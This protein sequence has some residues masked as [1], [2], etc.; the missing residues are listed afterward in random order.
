MAKRGN[1]EGHIRKRKDGR[2]EAAVMHQGKRRSVYG[3]TR[4]EVIQ[5]LKEL[6]KQ[7]ERGQD[8]SKK[9]LT[10]AEFLKGRRRR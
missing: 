2:Y 6:N 1:G 10:V 4:A 5:K 9:M 3:K 8:L 7:I